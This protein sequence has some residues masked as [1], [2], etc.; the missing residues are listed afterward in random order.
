MQWWVDLAGTLSLPLLDRFGLLEVEHQGAGHSCIPWFCV[1]TPVSIHD[2]YIGFVR[3][4]CSH[5][6][7]AHGGWM[8]GVNVSEHE[9]YLDLL[10]TVGLTADCLSE[11]KGLM[12]SVYP[13]DATDKNLSSLLAQPAK[14]L[15]SLGPLLSDATAR[16]RLRIFVLADNSD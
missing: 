3:E 12:E 15:T 10:R 11:F 9:Q 4:L 6:F 1:A 2:A 13:M 7:H 8:D 14:A 16:E 5:F